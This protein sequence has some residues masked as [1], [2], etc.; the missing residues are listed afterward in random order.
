MTNPAEEPTSRPWQWPREWF[1]DEKFWRDVGSRTLAAVIA[2][3]IVY[4]FA[5]AAG[6]VARPNILRV[7]GTAGVLA[8]EL[9][10]LFKLARRA[11]RRLADLR[12]KVA[13]HNMLHQLTGHE[14][15]DAW[16]KLQKAI[17]RLERLRIVAYVSFILTPPVILIVAALL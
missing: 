6:Y 12:R 11:E 15:N 4:V 7:A 8:V 14:S 16:R 3:G 13:R 5:L 2:A 1:H 10:I 17:A 9:F